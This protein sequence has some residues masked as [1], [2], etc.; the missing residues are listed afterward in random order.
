MRVLLAT[1]C[2]GLFDGTI[3]ARDGSDAIPERPRSMR[4]FEGVLIVSHHMS[5]FD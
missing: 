2:Q 4:K 3:D 5:V 1:R